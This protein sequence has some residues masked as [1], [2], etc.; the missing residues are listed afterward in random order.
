MWDHVSRRLVVS[1]A[2]HGF[3]RNVT[4]LRLRLLQSMEVMGNEMKT[5]LAAAGYWR[6]LANCGWWYFNYLYPYPYPYPQLS[7]IFLKILLILDHPPFMM[8]GLD[9][10]VPENCPDPDLSMMYVYHK[11]DPNNIGVSWNRGLPLVIIHF[12]RMFHEINHPLLGTF[13][14][15]ETRNWVSTRWCPPVFN[16]R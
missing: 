8:Y 16:R 7:L 2:S 12:N 4:G 1:H 5:R 9:R 11:I 3:L 13:I 10:D 14:C 6:C 15:A